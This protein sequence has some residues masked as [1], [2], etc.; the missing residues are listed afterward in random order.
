[1]ESKQYGVRE[2]VYFLSRR[3]KVKNLGNWEYDPARD[4]WI[5]P[6]GQFMKVQLEEN[7]SRCVCVYSG[8]LLPYEVQEFVDR[9]MA[10]L[11]S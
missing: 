7:D 10:E 11:P 9:M 6:S 5:H 8:G 3:P 1:M 2:L 4:E